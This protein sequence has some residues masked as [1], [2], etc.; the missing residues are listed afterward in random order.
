MLLTTF[1]ILL[2]SIGLVVHERARQL[3]ADAKYV[4]IASFEAERAAEFGLLISIL[5]APWF[6]IAAI[7]R[8][9]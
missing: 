2:M 9:S 8:Y 3:A 6:T 4:T 7:W 1:A 5:T